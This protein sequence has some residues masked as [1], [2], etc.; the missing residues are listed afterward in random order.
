MSYTL[1]YAPKGLDLENNDI[2]CHTF[3]E[4][5]DVHQFVLDKVM[6]S[7]PI[8]YLVSFQEEVF[9][10]ENSAFVAELFRPKDGLVSCYPYFEGDEVVIYEMESYEEAYKVAIDIKEAVSALTYAD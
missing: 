8:V 2:P 9:V 1:S 3:K 10:T 6:T 7:K 5:Q 4:K